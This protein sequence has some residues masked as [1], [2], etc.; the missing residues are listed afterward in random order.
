[1]VATVS[2]LGLLQGDPNKAR[3]TSPLLPCDIRKFISF[4]AVDQVCFS[5]PRC[6]TNAVTQNGRQ[7]YDVMVERA[8]P[9]KTSGPK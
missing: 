3:R 8:G 2:Y 7:L 5:I 6:S 9:S 1:M 4:Y